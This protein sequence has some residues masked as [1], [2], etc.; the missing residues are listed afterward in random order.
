LEIAIGREHRQAM[1]NTQ[2]S[3]ERID[4]SNLYARSPATIAQLGGID[5][6][7]PVRRQEREC[8]KPIQYLFSRFGAVETLEQFLQDETCRQDALASFQGS[9]QSADLRFIRRCITPKCQRPDARIDEKAQL[10]ERSDL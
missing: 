4:R 7:A 1:T 9:D 3:K 2:L 5:V 6:I 8:G 10:R